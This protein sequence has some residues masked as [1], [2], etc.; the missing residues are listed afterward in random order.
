VKANRI[1]RS[2]I[3]MLALGMTACNLPSSQ[4]NV[5][6]AIASTLT[7][8]AG[9]AQ[10]VLPATSPT[11]TETSVPPSSTPQPPAPTPVLATFTPSGTFFVVV[12]GANCRS[13]PD[14]FYDKTTSFQPGTY[15]TLVGHNADNSWWYVLTGSTNCWISASTG[16]TT[17]ALASLPLI[18]APP[19]P[20]A[21]G[22]GTGPVLAGPIA[23]VAEVSYPSNCASN[24]VQVA[25]HVTDNGNG[26]NS[27]W[28]NYR[29]LGDG[30]YTGNWHTVIPNDNAPGGINGFNY[31]I[32][33]EA[34][35]ELGTQNGTLQYQFFARDN[36]GN[37]SSYPGGSSLGMPIKYCP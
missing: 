8:M 3:F 29:Y 6:D 16:H 22:T 5:N 4:Q 2:I 24:T 12:T 32:G 34:K 36:S 35:S 23:L 15:L 31:P 26:I 20:T 19:T 27:V 21:T 14:T 9:T 1:A 33:L 13:G 7:A 28:L 25:I 18:T 10:V 11:F 17:D 30:G 37:T